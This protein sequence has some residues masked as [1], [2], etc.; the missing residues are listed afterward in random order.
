MFAFKVLNLRTCSEKIITILICLSSGLLSLIFSSPYESL[1]IPHLPFTLFVLL[2]SINYALYGVTFSKLYDKNKTESC[3]LILHLLC[4][5]IISLVLPVLILRFKLFFTSSILSV[6][7]FCIFL[8]LFKKCLY[9]KK[10]IIHLS[11]HFIFALYMF[12]L[13]FSILY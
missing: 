10:A 2:L 9:M 13:T 4:C 11:L 3:H 8:S 12:Y 7:Y 6:I 1:S 5:F